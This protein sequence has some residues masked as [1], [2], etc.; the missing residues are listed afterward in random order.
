MQKLFSK[1]PKPQPAPQQAHPQ[2][3]S[4]DQAKA[5]IELFI[6]KTEEKIELKKKENEI[7]GRKI[8]D[9]LK[10]GKKDLAKRVLI[11]KKKNE[12]F[13]VSAGKK[14]IFMEKAMHH[15]EESISTQEMAETLTETNKILE[16]NREK[17]DE[18]MD[19]VHQVKEM[20]QASEMAH[21]E[22]NE[23]MNQNDDEE[24]E[25]LE[26]MMKEY[27]EQ[28]NQEMKDKFKQADEQMGIQA[29]QK[30]PPQQQAAKQK[31]PP[32]KEFDALMKELLN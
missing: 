32:K 4:S 15:I 14:I 31:E 12:E 23:L 26:A 1:T 17:H 18:I 30:N 10:E 13:I 7:M 16:K 19:N 22:L 8:V 29:K 9:L 27:E 3:A 28:V 6:A 11:R 24:D 25:D 21:Q 2:L 5:K 20:K